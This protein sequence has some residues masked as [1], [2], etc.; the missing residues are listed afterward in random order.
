[1]IAEKTLKLIN[2]AIFA[3]QGN[4]FRKYSEIYLP[5]MHDA[6]RE[7]DSSFRT[8]LGASLI[9]KVCDRELWYSFHWVKQPIF[10]ARILRLFNRGHLEEARFLAMLKAA[11][12]QVWAEENGKQFRVNEHNGHFGGS[13]DGIGLGFPEFPKTPMLLEFKTHGHKSF[14]KLMREG[15]QVAKWQHYVQMQMYMFKQGLLKGMYMAVCK[16]TDDLYAEIIRADSDLAIKYFDRAY[17]IIYSKMPPEKL[18]NCPT[19][20]ECK[21]CDYKKICT[22]KLRPLSN[23]RTCASAAL[24]DKGRWLCTQFN[25][26]IDKGKQEE[27]CDSHQFIEGI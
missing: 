7:N 15:M 25:Q 5:T 24:R 9:G 23:C 10:D 14:N 8:H 2:D 22:G 13:L 27:G 1:M 19:R 3:D 26:F 16:D 18:S 12:I 6:Y 11:G 21:Y 4:S 17:N 20:F